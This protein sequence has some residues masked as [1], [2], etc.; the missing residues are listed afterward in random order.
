MPLKCKGLKKAK[1]E[2]PNI[3]YSSAK[4]LQP[5][6]SDELDLPE[7]PDLSQVYEYDIETIAGKDYVILNK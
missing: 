2:C 4:I 6:I 1:G 7:K 3:L 5:L